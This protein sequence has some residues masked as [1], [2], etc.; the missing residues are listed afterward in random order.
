VIFVEGVCLVFV[1]VNLFGFVYFINYKLIIII[2]Y[3]R[4]LVC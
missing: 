3:T 1:T 2:N 4:L